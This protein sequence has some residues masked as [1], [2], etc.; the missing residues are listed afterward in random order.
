MVVSLL[1]YLKLLPI[2]VHLESVIRVID[3]INR[4]MHEGF[5]EI[6]YEGEFLSVASAALLR[7]CGGLSHVQNQIDIN[8]DTKIC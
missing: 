3:G 5:V 8:G 7:Q 6:Q 1:L 2:E 4:T